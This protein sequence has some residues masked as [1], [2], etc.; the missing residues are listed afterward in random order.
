MKRVLFVCAT[1]GITSTVA[2]KTV[3]DAC[4]D[5]GVSITTLR[6]SPTQIESHLGNID[7]IVTTTMLGDVYPVPVIRA[8]E[9]ITGIG[10]EKALENIVKAIKENSV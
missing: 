9:L 5:A 1:G 10:K 2:E 4:K 7:I 8:L 6:S 3:Q